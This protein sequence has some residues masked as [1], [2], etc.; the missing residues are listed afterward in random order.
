VFGR[1]E[2][3]NDG[4]EAVATKRSQIE[5]YARV[6]GVPAQALNKMA[7]L[8]VVMD[9]WM[10]EYELDATA[11]QCWTSME[12]Y[13]GVVPCT[14]MSMLSNKLAP[15]ACETDVAG[16]VGMLAL[17]YASGQPSALMD[18][19]NNYG[20]DPDKAV[21]FHCSNLPAQIFA[22]IPVM[23]YQAIIAG[24]VG[25][26]NTFGTVVGRI[27]AEPFTYLRLSTE[28]TLGSISAYMGEGEFTTDPI[29]TFGGY[30]VVRI[31]EMQNLL[32]YICENG[33]EHH[34]AVNQSLV[35][36]GVYEALT[37]YLDWDVYL[38]S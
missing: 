33:F 11:V 23:D 5:S 31:P 34:V 35:A 12:E 30:G 29:D 32:A 28:D 4:E 24:T 2:R 3:L 17:Q 1:I 36:G 10:D 26:E 38:H 15:S 13:F 9:R 16:V 7:K 14:V 27:K 19:N 8:G 37:K 25:R 22:D 6:Q 18:W 21:V 20:E